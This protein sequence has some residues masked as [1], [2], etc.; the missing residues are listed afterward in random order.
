MSSIYK[1]ESKTKLNKDLSTRHRSRAIKKLI[2][3][4]IRW[5]LFTPSTNCLTI[6]LL[7]QAFESL[8]YLCLDYTAYPWPTG[9]TDILILWDNCQLQF[10]HANWWD[11]LISWLCIEDWSV[12]ITK[13]WQ[14][15]QLCLFLL[16]TFF[17]LWVSFPR[18]IITIIQILFCRRHSNHLTQ[19]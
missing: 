5:T 13:F 7:Y 19:R 3:S 15:S 14:N 9:I 12:Q 17:L 16:G 2:Y 8:S 6:S 11:F 1:G 18:V 4:E 10:G